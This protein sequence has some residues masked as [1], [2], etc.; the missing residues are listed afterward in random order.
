MVE[1]N[2]ST[3][4]RL[5]ATGRDGRI[6]KGDVVELHGA[7]SRLARSRVKRRQQRPAV[8]QH[9]PEPPAAGPARADDAPA[10]AHRRA[11]GARRSTRRRMLTT[12]NESR[13]QGGHGSARELQG[14]VR[15]ESTGVKLGFMSFFVKA[16]IEAL[17]RFPVVN[18]SRRRQRHRLSRVLRHRRRRLHRS[19]PDGAG[20]ARCD[21]MSFAADR[22][23][24]RRICR[25][26][27]RRH[28]HASRNSPAGRFTITNGGMFGSLLSTPI[29]N[30]A[31][32]RNPRHACKIQERP[33]VV[34]GQ[35]VVR[36]M[37]YVALILRSPHHRRPRGRAVPRH[38]QG[39][40][41]RSGATAA[42]SLRNMEA[43]WLTNTM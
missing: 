6:T 2:S 25:Q 3:Q 39:M 30:I 28:D 24:H 11:P 36:P 15:E 7:R 23:D 18:A 27:A 4:P 8:P 34:D 22:E 32:E 21:L 14:S 43:T 37:M 35:I 42:G 1:E 10:R 16:A 13:P 38:D 41:R 40:P 9:A 17:K 29:V 31:A 12:F 20:P 33:M 19:R 26:G 5:P